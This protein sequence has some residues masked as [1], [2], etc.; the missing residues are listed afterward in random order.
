MARAI[1]ICQGESG[2]R[3]IRLGEGRTT[4][5]RGTDANE[6]IDDSGLSRI[7]ASVYFENGRLWVVDENSTNGSLVNGVRVGSSGTP[8]GEADRIEIGNHTKLTVRLD[9]DEAAPAPAAPKTAAVSARPAESVESSGFPMLIV[10][11]ALAFGLLVI[12][13]SATVIGIR[14]WPDKPAEITQDLED[15]DPTP[16]PDKG[17]KN[18]SKSATPE[19]SST[20]TP[21]GS[22][23]EPIGNTIVETRTNGTTVELPKGRYQDMSEADKDRYIAVKAEKIAQIIGNQKAEPIPPAAVARIKRDLNEYVRRLSQSK[24]DNCNQGSWTRSDFT[25]V[26]QRATKT[27][28]FVIRSFR[29]KGLE[30]QIG[31]YVAMI[32]SEHCSCLTSP[33]GAKGMFQF[34]ASTWRDYDPEN[35]P[36]NRCVPEKAANAGADYLKVLITRYGTAPDSIL[37]AIASFNSGQGN[38]SRNLDQVLSNAVGQD[39]SFWTI[40]AN[41]ELLEGKSGQQFKGEN[42]KYVPKFF[43]TAIIGENP[44]DFGAPIRPLS[45]YTQ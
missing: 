43:A 28:P 3:E 36:D 7:H 41:T 5:G 21:A 20:T 32:E 45:T 39:R 37:L 22:P 35:N 11:G 2:T 17:N 10:L 44:Q 24:N 13:V 18:G 25:S 19:S 31:I 38:L 33:T 8:L 40:M 15:E 14:Y 27:S 26:L 4:F 23:E 12:G 1:L 29:A 6:R 9:S 34:L 16:T 30:P 42:I